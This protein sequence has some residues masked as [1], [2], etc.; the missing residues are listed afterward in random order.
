MRVV[1]RGSDGGRGT[2]RR[3]NAVEEVE[4]VASLGDR[5]ETGNQ[6]GDGD[7]PDREVHTFNRELDGSLVGAQHDVLSA[8]DIDED[9]FEARQGWKEDAFVPLA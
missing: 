7:G 1:Q 4:L 8:G 3:Q 9:M 6:E 5:I 2:V